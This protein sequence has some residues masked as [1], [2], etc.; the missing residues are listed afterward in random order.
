MKDFE[1]KVIDLAEKHRKNILKKQD[2]H[3]NQVEK[4][5]DNNYLLRLLELYIENSA[6]DDDKRAA[7][8][9]KNITQEH[10]DTLVYNALAE[11]AEVD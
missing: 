6:S 3:V 7:K 11:I 5:N 8:L 10:L 2:V 1:I 9:K 4:F